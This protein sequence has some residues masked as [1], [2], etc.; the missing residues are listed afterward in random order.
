M[1]IK[2]RRLMFQKIKELTMCRVLLSVDIGVDVVSLDLG[3]TSLKKFEI[4]SLSYIP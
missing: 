4:G 2:M 1:K 3:L